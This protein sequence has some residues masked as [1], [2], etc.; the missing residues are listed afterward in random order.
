M[1]ASISD[2]ACRLL[3]CQRRRGA[4]RT[5]MIVRH[6]GSIICG[7]VV[8]SNSL[9]RVSS[10]SS[11]T[12]APSPSAAHQNFFTHQSFTRQGAHCE[13]PEPANP[14]HHLVAPSPPAN[15]PAPVSAALGTLDQLRDGAWASG[16]SISE[17]EPAAANLNPCLAGLWHPAQSTAISSHDPA[18]EWTV[19]CPQCGRDSTK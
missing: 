3:Y 5:L 7:L 11:G 9:G 16:W 18:T 4:S 13:K 19:D 8:R 1:P 14:L 17:F 10:W 15:Q 6:G 2:V 12:D